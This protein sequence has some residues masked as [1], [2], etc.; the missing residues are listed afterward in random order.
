MTEE[1]GGPWV[2]SCYSTADFSDEIQSMLSPHSGGLNGE[3]RESTPE[4]MSAY[5]RVFFSSAAA[6]LVWTLLLAWTQDCA[7]VSKLVAFQ[8]RHRPLF[9]DTI[10]III[11]IIIICNFIPGHGDTSQNTLVLTD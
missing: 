1:H 2:R 11:I 6:D 4:N 10:I 5:L 3:W 8:T 7:N 9:Q